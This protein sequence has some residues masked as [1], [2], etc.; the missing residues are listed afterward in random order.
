MSNQDVKTAILAKIHELSKGLGRD[1]RKLKTSDSIPMSEVLDSAG[2]MELMLW[3]EAEFGLN[4]PQEDYS[5]ENFGS[6]DLM[7]TY[8]ADHGTR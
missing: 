1:S 4:I 7:A 5:L 8:L 3:Y 6:V 2:L